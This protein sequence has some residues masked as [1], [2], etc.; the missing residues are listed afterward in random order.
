[1]YDVKF[2]PHIR[3]KNFR[4]L[5]IVQF[6]QKNTSQKICPFWAILEKSLCFFFRIF[7]SLF[8]K[9]R[10]CGP[11]WLL[12]FSNRS[13]FYADS[14]SYVE[15]DRIRQAPTLK[16][17]TY[18]PCTCTNFSILPEGRSRIGRPTDEGSTTRPSPL[19][20]GGWSCRLLNCIQTIIFTQ[21]LDRRRFD[22]HLGLGT[23]VQ[24]NLHLFYPFFF[25]SLFLLKAQP[26]P[27]RH[28]PY[29]A[30]KK[31]SSLSFEYLLYI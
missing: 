11:F 20:T 1:M 17:N 30:A 3:W 29:L 13:E 21:I 18:N 6:L 8:A 10:L 19:V 2:E 28:W 22:S 9:K 12:F 15:S 5:E 7:I 27:H 31:I 14:E 24:R 16:S 4:M 25:H 23:F 26:F